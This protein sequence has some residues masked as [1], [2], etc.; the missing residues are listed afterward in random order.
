MQKFVCNQPVKH[1]VERSCGF[2]NVSCYSGLKCFA[3]SVKEV[4][5]LALYGAEVFVLFLLL[6]Y[7][8]DFVSSGIKYFLKL[9]A[10][11]VRELKLRLQLAYRLLHNRYLLIRLNRALATLKVLGE[12]GEN[13]QPVANINGAGSRL[14]PEIVQQLIDPTLQA[15]GHITCEP[16]EI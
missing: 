8:P 9:L 5:N 13:R 11:R 16:K 3:V 2:A 7:L 6:L 14:G 10:L 12:S 1:I 4:Q 15:C